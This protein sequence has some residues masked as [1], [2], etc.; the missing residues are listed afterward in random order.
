LK[1]LGRITGE[2]CIKIIEIV[3]LEISCELL[4]ADNFPWIIYVE[5]FAK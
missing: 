4:D 2:V 1:L 5:I 3:V